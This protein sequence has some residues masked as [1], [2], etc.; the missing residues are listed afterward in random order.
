MRH[1]HRNKKELKEDEEAEKRNVEP[2]KIVILDFGEMSSSPSENR[3]WK[4]IVENYLWGLF[5]GHAITVLTLNTVQY[6]S[7]HGV[8]WLADARIRS[9]RIE[10]NKKFKVEIE[11]IV[12]WLGTAAAGD[13]DA[14]IMAPVC[15]HTTHV[16]RHLVGQMENLK[17]KKRRNW[18]WK[19]QICVMWFEFYSMPSSPLPSSSLP[20]SLLLCSWRWN[21]SFTRHI[22]PFRQTLQ[23]RNSKNSMATVQTERQQQQKS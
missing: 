3:M 14:T 7:L 21:V 5:Y 20:R 12:T 2:V 18:G 9:F 4:A 23:E 1:R 17:E 19:L 15:T 13:A 22:W 8:A 10:S 16:T 11:R 6:S